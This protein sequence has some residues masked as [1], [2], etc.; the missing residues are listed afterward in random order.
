MRNPLIVGLV[1]LFVVQSAKADEPA[2]FDRDIV[3]LLKRNCVKCHGPVTQEGKL[4]LAT[5]NGLIRGGKSGAAIVPH[6]V[7]GSLI[8]QRVTTD[9]MP[10][11]SPLSAADKSMLK[12]WIADGSKGLKRTDDNAEHW[13]FRRLQTSTSPSLKSS[14]NSSM[15]VSSPIDLFLLSDLSRDGLSYLPEADRH[16]LIRRVSLDVTGLPPS[17]ADI[18]E[19]VSDTRPDA[20]ERMVD[21]CLSSPHFGERMGKVWLDAAGY[22]DSNGYFNADSDRPLAYRY[23]DYVIRSLNANKP[24]DDFIREQIAGDEI[25]AMNVRMGE[26][27]TLPDAAD[28]SD[29]AARTI[30]LMEATHFL[31]N[32]QDGTGESDGNADEVR[33]DRYTVIETTMQNISTSLLGLTIQCAKCHDHKFEPLTQLDYYSLQAVLIPAFPPET[34]KKPNERFIYAVRTSE[35]EAWKKLV[36]ENESTV[37]RLQAEIHP[38]VVANRP[39]GELLFNDPFDSSPESLGHGWSNTAP[40]DDMPGGSAAVNVNSRVAPAAVIADGRLLLIEGGPG[41]D[42]WLSTKQSY[43]WTPDVVGAS[44][45]V[46]FDLV[47]NQIETSAPAER[48][49]YFIATH[50][51]HN[52]SP[53]PGGNILIDGHP[54]AG[55]SVMLDYPGPGAKSVGTVGKT[56]YVPGRNYGVRVT[57]LGNG[58]FQLQQLVDW[59]VDE[60]GI[61]LSEADLPSGGFGF[62]YCCG[63]SFVVDN[64]SIET[65]TPKEGNDPLATFLKELAERRKPL[66]DAIKTKT[67]FKDSRPGKIAWTTDIAD[68]VPP[69][70]VFERGNYATLGQLVEAAGYAVL[71]Q[72]MT[73]GNPPSEGNSS[74]TS[75]RRLAFANW[76]TQSNSRPASLMARV[77]VNRFW[78]LA[79]GTGLV[80][81]ADNFGLSGPPPSNQELLDRLA[82]DFVTSGWNI[83]QLFRSILTSDA[84][85]QS[86]HIG[87][88]GGGKEIDSEITGSK[89]RLQ[90][91]PDARRLSRFPVRRLDAEAIRDSL[92]FASGSFD[93]RLYGPY[94]PTTRTGNGET[95]VPEDKPGALRR[96]I[97]LQQRRTQVHSLLQVFDAPSIVFNSTRRARSTMPLQS[98]S[99]LNSEFV[100]ARAESLSRRLEQAAAGESDRLHQAFLSAIGRPP[101]EDEIA[102]AMKFLHDQRLE[103]GDSSEADFRAWSNLCQALLI[104]NA[105]LYVD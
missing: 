70:H 52:N 30:E 58:Q 15:A 35:Q 63:R 98:L 97:Y 56:G 11:E 78:Q 82:N 42:K 50:D 9:E 59:Q 69:V 65:F 85:R 99:L 10:P 51:F 26:T 17:P 27:A 102:T 36:A 94:V 37:E 39:H 79:F 83:K 60:P 81:T 67:A 54:S 32:G 4:N 73:L 92:L 71:E 62:E 23:R 41:G 34:W 84:Y 3:P 29:P 40:G 22:A 66:D 12:T 100:V 13:A 55:T 14:D 88:P 77:Q 86:S 20:F 46:T 68:P 53:T 89:S 8:W 104:D 61:K 96:S 105:A 18:Q 44:I 91:D 103:Y 24:F 16:T 93:D 48:I 49:G 80:V 28:G 38:W 43:D 64:V 19:F 90:F 21:R 57:N 75:G 74:T 31:R 6:D 87:S 45:Q 76:L 25:A 33:I 101:E 5:A 1:G 47:D 72:P 95:V 7:E 2:H